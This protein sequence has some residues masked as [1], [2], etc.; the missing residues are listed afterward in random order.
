VAATRT[1]VATRTAVGIGAS[2][3]VIW[4]GDSL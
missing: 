2:R 1:V 4:F 3:D